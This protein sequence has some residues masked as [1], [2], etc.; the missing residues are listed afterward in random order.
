MKRTHS[1][2]YREY[3]EIILNLDPE[4]TTWV[5]MKKLLDEILCSDDLTT[6]ERIQLADVLDSK[7]FF[8]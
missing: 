6:S 4:A 1:K 2:A 8:K 7:E 5:E 3:R